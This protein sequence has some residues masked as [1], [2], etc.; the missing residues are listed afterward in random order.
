M[1]QVLGQVAGRAVAVRRPLGQGAQADPVQLDRDRV[2]Q[3]AGR[4]RLLRLDLLQNFIRA[5]APVRPLSGEQLVEDD[6]QAV[7]VGAGIDAVPLAAGLFRA[8]VGRRAGQLGAGAEVHIAQ[9]Q[10]EV[11]HHGPALFVEQDVGR[12][13]VAVDQAA[14]VGV[15]QGFG[16]LGDEGCRF[17][18]GGPGL[19]QPGPQILAG[20]ELGNHVA[21]AVGGP[22]HVVDGHD[23]RVVQGRQHAGLGQEGLDVGRRGDAVA[24]RHL[25]GHVALQVVVVGLVD[26]AEGAGAEPG[27]DA[28]AAQ[29]RGQKVRCQETGVRSQRSSA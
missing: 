12:L 27:R 18:A 4:A 7:D 28:V 20:D 13:D 16:H 10:A 3:L 24:V 26:H 6:A 17:R 19:P 15:V 23:A 9:R 1:P 29:V 11:C 14:A 25:D 8:H 5:L 21:E 22:A 2:V